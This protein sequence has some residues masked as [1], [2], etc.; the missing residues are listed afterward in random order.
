[1]APDLYSR[2]P[3]GVRIVLGSPV[4]SATLIAFGLNLAL[5][6]TRPAPTADGETEAEMQTRPTPTTPAEYVP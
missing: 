4:T 3:D 6:R 2:F 1:M 5:N